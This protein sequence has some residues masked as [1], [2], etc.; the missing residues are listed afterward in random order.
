MSTQALVVTLL[1][2]VLIGFWVAHLLTTVTV[3]FVVPGAQSPDVDAASRDGERGPVRLNPL[4]STF[5]DP[6]DPPV[7]EYLEQTT[8][9]ATSS[10]TTS[11]LSPRTAAATPERDADARGDEGRR[12]TTVVEVRDAP[13]GSGK[14][15]VHRFAGSAS[16]EEFEAQLEAS[17]REAAAKERTPEA[18]TAVQTPEETPAE[19]ADTLLGEGCTFA[20]GCGG[21]YSASPAVSFFFPP[22][23]LS[24][25][26]LSPLFLPVSSRTS[27][28]PLSHPL[29][30]VLPPFLCQ[31]TALL[32]STLSARLCCHPARGVSV[33]ARTSMA[34]RSW[35]PCPSMA[36]DGRRKGR[37]S[38]FS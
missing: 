38:T 18:T 29:L 28:I 9:G 6:S 17:A 16:K 26:P 34:R 27:T 24:T 14:Y 31:V 1:S 36:P 5:S 25:I 15:I 2:G 33:Y 8:G 3:S 11:S 30:L 7:V 35:R 20:W 37:R 22:P 23:H 21:K 12:G 10:A 13:S 32:L 4:P 19:T